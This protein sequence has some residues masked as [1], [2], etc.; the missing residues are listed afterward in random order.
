[1]SPKSEFFLPKNGDREEIIK[2]GVQKSLIN[3][4]KLGGQI[5]KFL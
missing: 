4:G 5:F 1:M 3:Q 2:V